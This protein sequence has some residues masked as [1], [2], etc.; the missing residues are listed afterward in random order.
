MED[1]RLSVRA[2]AA[3]AGVA[4]DTWRAYVTRRKAP[5]PDGIDETFGRRW[6]WRSTV[7]RWLEER[8]GQGSR[9]DLAS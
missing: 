5:Q 9:S 2:A 3:L 1:E 7:L 8:P 4:V 6:W